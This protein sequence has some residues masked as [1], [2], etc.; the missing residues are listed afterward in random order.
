MFWLLIPILAL[1]AAGITFWIRRK[2]MSSYVPSAAPAFNSAGAS[3]AIR[4]EF[5]A[6]QTAVNSKADT[7]SPTF[8]GTTTLGVAVLTGDLSTPD[9]SQQVLTFKVG[10]TAAGTA[11]RFTN[12]NASQTYLTIQSA[13]DTLLLGAVGGIWINGTQLLSTTSELNKLS[14]CTATTS[15]LNKLAGTPA[16]LTSTE[17]GY[18][19]GVTSSIQNQLNT[20]VSPG[21]VTTITSASYTVLSSDS[22]IIANLSGT[23]TLFLPAASSYPGRTLNVKTITANS[24]VSPANNVYPLQSGTLGSLIVINSAGAWA[25]LQSDGTNWVV[26]AGS[27]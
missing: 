13:D 2:N 6:I 3:A 8:T 7:A 23:C 20:K 19:D 17:L 4:S 9:N 24:V 5:T 15:E 1:V 26:M 22:S 27:P 16:G 10:D 21:N 18:V 14:G 12:H 11:L 25:T